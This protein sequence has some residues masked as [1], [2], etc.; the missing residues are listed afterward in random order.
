[1][2]RTAAFHTL[3]CK[4]NQYETEKIAALFAENGFS[5]LSKEG[6]N[7]ETDRYGAGERQ[8]ENLP[9]PAAE[10]D[11][12]AAVIIN[13]CTV[14]G[15]ADRKS[16]NLI[17]RASRLEPR[18]VIAVIGCYAEVD[19]ETVQAM[20]GVDI[21]LGTKNKE[22]VVPR[23]LAALHERESMKGAHT[24]AAPIEA[25]ACAPP[26]PAEEPEGAGADEL[27][28]EAGDSVREAAAETLTVC[29]ASTSI[30][31]PVSCGNAPRILTDAAG[32]T[33]SLTRAYIKIED[34][35]DRYCSYCIIPR[36]RGRVRSRSVSSIVEEAKELLRDGYREIVLTGINTALYGRE[37]GAGFAGTREGDALLSLL[38]GL[39]ALDGDFRIRLSSLE[40]TVINSREVKG[41]FAF[42]KLCHHLH[43]SAQ[44][45]SDRVLAAMHRRYTAEEYRDIVRTLR[46]FDPLYGISTDII[47]GF[48]TETEEDFQESMRLVEDARYVRTHIFPFS[49][50]TGTPAEKLQPQIPASVKHA[51]VRALQEVA[52]RTAQN[53]CRDNGGKKR[54]VIFEECV[55]TCAE[56]EKNTASP[57]LLC[58]YTDSYIRVYAPGDTSLIGTLRDVEL[59]AVYKD[60]MKGEIR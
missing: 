40:P 53:F 27:A 15:M 21:V 48:P 58:G 3:G 29:T 59:L 33:H 52:E 5:I 11:V 34:G 42:D 20:E 19:A 25:P 38:S 8:A 43:L 51:R 46:A 57:A 12:P 24:Q 45:G 39:N 23:V 17:R 37:R 1:M 56:T 7:R 9:S 28:V 2:K 30:Q 18:P 47:T 32:A 60:G 50:R 13:T 22:E 6:K 54:K 14:T 31:A 4:V 44:S 49:P 41:L 10:E 55:K 35:C 16:R 26:V 36:A